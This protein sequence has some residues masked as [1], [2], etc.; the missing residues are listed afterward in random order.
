MLIVVVILFFVFFVLTAVLAAGLYMSSKNIWIF[1]EDAEDSEEDVADDA[2]DDVVEAEV[3]QLYAVANCKLYRLSEVSAVEV[4]FANSTSVDCFDK[5]VFR[6]NYA[7]VSPD[8]DSLILLTEAE[9]NDEYILDVENAV[10][11][12]VEFDHDN[13]LSVAV[14]PVNGTLYSYLSDDGLYSGT[15]ANPLQDELRNFDSEIFGRGGIFSEDFRMRVSPDGTLILIEDTFTSE[16]A[17]GS[18]FTSLKVIDTSGDLVYETRGS[19][20]QFVDNSRIVF[21]STDSMGGGGSGDVTVVNLD[22]S[23][24]TVLDI[25]SRAY[26][27]DF[28]DGHVL[29]DYFDSEEDIA[30]GDMRTV[31]LND[32]DFSVEETLSNPMAYNMMLSENILVGKTSTNCAGE[33]DSGAARACAMEG[34]FDFYE[35][36]VSSLNIDT[37]ANTVLIEFDTVTQPRWID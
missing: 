31:I 11:H 17:D 1:E 10:V 7:S 29:V 33:W 4:A 12:Q 28:I 25:S 21:S 8:Y 27:I 36:D 30:V 34:A 19:F 14:N 2:A 22:T 6:G 16:N 37:D 13:A 24:E 18:E 23:A 32:E 9:K 20:A 35:E 3:Q 5:K 15:Y 26:S